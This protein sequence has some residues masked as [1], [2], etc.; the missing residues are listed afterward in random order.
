[1]VFPYFAMPIWGLES[2]ESHTGS[3]RDPSE[4]FADLIRPG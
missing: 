3:F 4:F 1:M 2:I